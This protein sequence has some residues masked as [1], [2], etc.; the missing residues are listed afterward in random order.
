MR[1]NEQRLFISYIQP[2]HKVSR[3][4]IFRW[5][6]SV[7]ESAGIDTVMFTAHSTRA[8][9]A[10]KAKQK[11][12]PLDVILKTVGWKSENTFR[13]FYDKRITDTGDMGTA[14]LSP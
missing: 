9:A 6:K 7:L 1:N 3:D 13:K 10:S 5:T 4:A 11:A 2:H 8:A 12:I 14:L